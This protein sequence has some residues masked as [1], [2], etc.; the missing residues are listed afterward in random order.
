M[1]NRVSFLLVAIFFVTMNVL[2]WRSEYAAHD[3]SGSAVPVAMVWTKILNA[4]DNSSLQILRHGVMVG[5]CRWGTEVTEAPVPKDALPEEIVRQPTGFRVTVNGNLSLQGATNRL[6]FDGTLMLM[7]NQDWRT[8][9]LRFVRY[10]G[11]GRRRESLTLESD[12]V[13]QSVWLRLGS[14]DG[15]FEQEFK[16]AELQNPAAL[17]EQYQLP[18]PFPT[19]WLSAAGTNATLKLGLNWTA[20]STWL[21]FGHTPTRVYRLH[22]KLL[23]G[24]EVVI[25]V[26]RAGEILRAEFPGDLLLLNDRAGGT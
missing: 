20:R 26:S 13:A 14:A 12:A 4:P 11:Q 10:R 16:F 5:F 3:N 15:G 23:E 19:S 22:A 7:T 17:L 1:L 6:G 8:L 18:M 24:Y 9:N 2:L 25:I 21:N